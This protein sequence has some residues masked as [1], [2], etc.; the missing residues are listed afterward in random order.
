MTQTSKWVIYD[1]KHCLFACL[2]QTYVPQTLKTSCLQR[3]LVQDI[4]VLEKLCEEPLK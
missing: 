3:R 1:C 4:H 2:V